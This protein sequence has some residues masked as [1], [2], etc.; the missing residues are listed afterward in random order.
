MNFDQPTAD[1]P[2]F[3][4]VGIEDTNIG[5]P[6]RGSGE[7]LDEYA[8]TDHYAQWREDFDRVV[9]VGATTVRY[10]LPWYRVNPAPGK[11][12]WAWADEVIRYAVVDLGLDL[13]LD[14]VHY[15][16]PSWLEG[17]FTDP[18]YPAAVAEYAGAVA[19]RYDGLVN[20]FTPL[21]EPLVTASFTGARAIWPPYESGDAGWARVIVGVSAGIQSAIKA[22]KAAQPSAIIA[23]V[24]ATHVWETEDANLIAHRD[25]LR[26]RNF[27][28]TD[29]VL[30]RVTSDHALYPWLIEM[31]IG[32][33]VLAGFQEPCPAPD[34]IGVNFYPELSCRELVSIDGQ[35]V[36]VAFNG[37][38]AGL[39]QVTEEFWE[40]YRIPVFVSETAVEGEAEHLSSWIETVK[41]LATSMRADG[42]DLRGVTWWPLFDFV[43]WSWGSGGGVVEEFYTRVDG[44]IS[45]VIPPPPSAGI[46]AYFRRMGLWTLEENAGS[47]ARVRTS[48]AATFALAAQSPLQRLDEE[49]ANQ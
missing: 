21:N 14:L 42:I 6:L 46:A 12:D 47:I 37:W 31:G 41:S 49:R 44:I 8:S 3:W 28:P 38:D 5:W 25:T 26:L 29:L 34:L 27:L 45:P 19:A 2:F 39:R 11:W 9:E 7:F 40:R 30:G 32:P 35:P 23:H 18:G 22:I 36:G 33:S 20:K 43:D 24:E 13:I 4:A 17:S 15:G 10:G 1:H 16:T 48:A